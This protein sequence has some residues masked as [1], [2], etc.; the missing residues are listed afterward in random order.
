[1]NRDILATA[2]LNRVHLR[3]SGVSRLERVVAFNEEFAQFRRH[4]EGR[5]LR[6]TQLRR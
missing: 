6:K 2:A 5:G 4:E 1:M 3:K